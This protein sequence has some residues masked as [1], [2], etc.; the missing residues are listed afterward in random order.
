MYKDTVSP[1]EF[2]SYVGCERKHY[3]QYGLEIQSKT[4][5][6][7]LLRGT[8]GHHFLEMYFTDRLNGM[9]VRE[10]IAASIKYMAMYLIMHPDEPYGEDAK[11]AVHE[12][13]KTGG[14][15]DWTILAVEHEFKVA[16]P[17]SEEG[18]SILFKV[19]LIV[20]DL[21]GHI[22]IVDHKFKASFSNPYAYELMSQLPKYMGALQLDGH[23][24]DWVAYMEFKATGKQDFHLDQLD[25]SPARIKHTMH[26]HSL[27]ADRIIAK[28]RYVESEPEIGLEVWSNHAIR[29]QNTMICNNCPMKKICVAELNEQDAQGVLDANY[30]KK[31][32]SDGPTS[33]W[34]QVMHEVPAG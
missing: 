1:S 21:N 26:E 22:G 24:V 17:Y 15:A 11:K 23:Q 29:V 14:A 13:Y 7:S 30:Q 25:I 12:F 10:A 8:L 3:Y 27:I 33:D 5:S 32:Y 16:L 9:D 4:T 20:R 28:K 2:D 19:D 34:Q 18:A 31:V 6:D